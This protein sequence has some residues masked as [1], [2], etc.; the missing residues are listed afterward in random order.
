MVEITN[1]VWSFSIYV[2]M[3]CYSTLCDYVLL[4]YLVP[5]VGENSIITKIILRATLFTLWNMIV[6]LR[7]ESYLDF[8]TKERGENV[9]EETTEVTRG[10]GEIK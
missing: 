9:R 10:W 1:K 3:C 5:T 8:F 7:T 6:Y 2:I 4:F